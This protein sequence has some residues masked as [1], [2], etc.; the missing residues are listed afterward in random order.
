MIRRLILSKLVRERAL[1]S[2][3]IMEGIEFEDM[4]REDA[5]QRPLCFFIIRTLEYL[6][7]EYNMVDAD[8]K[9]RC[10]EG[11]V[12]A[13]AFALARIKY[14]YGLDLTTPAKNRVRHGHVSP[15][16]SRDGLIPLPLDLAIYGLSDFD[17]LRQDALIATLMADEAALAKRMLEDGVDVTK[18]S[19]IF[20]SPMFAAGYIGSD[21]IIRSILTLSIQQTE[22]PESHKQT[23]VL[24]DPYTGIEEEM[25]DMSRLQ[26]GAK[27]QLYMPEDLVLHGAVSGNRGSLVRSILGPA[28]SQDQ[29]P[30]TCDAFPHPPSYNGITEAID[31]ALRSKYLDIVSM[32][33]L[34]NANRHTQWFA[35]NY[36]PHLGKK[37]LATL[38]QS[39]DVHFKNFT[40]SNPEPDKFPFFLH[41]GPEKYCWTNFVYPAR[42][43]SIKKVFGVK[44]VQ[45]LL[46]EAA[47]QWRPSLLKNVIDHGAELNYKYHDR[48]LHPLVRAAGE[49]HWIQLCYMIEQFGPDLNNDHCG[50]QALAV[51]INKTASPGQITGEIFYDCMKLLRGR[52][53]LEKALDGLADGRPIPNF[54]R[55]DRGLLRRL[56]HEVKM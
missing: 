14:K 9:R 24:K 12:T 37:A 48:L 22:P 21:D 42:T 18:K 20:G 8:C 25:P 26:V 52:A 39:M 31:L 49:G 56:D 32:L 53:S 11:L 5:R 35:S 41:K 54:V 16:T 6:D 36:C 17:T 47:A 34:D 30:A 7:T 44:V 19:P 4:M 23:S 27:R 29:L 3:T 1:L 55:A 15:E 43:R 33:V 45:Q 13:M 38:Q 51:A 40:F 50:S 2:Y 10:I 28:E 46:S